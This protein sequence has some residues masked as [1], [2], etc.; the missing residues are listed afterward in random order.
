M[1]PGDR[2]S[3]RRLPAWRIAL[4][5]LPLGAGRDVGQALAR[6]ARRA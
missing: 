4:E 2:P 5:A 3:A 1:A 6:S